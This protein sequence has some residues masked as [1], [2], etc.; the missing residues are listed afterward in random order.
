MPVPLTIT[1]IEC[2]GLAARLPDD[3]ELGWDVD[4][5]VVYA[6]RDCN[7]RMDIVVEEDDLTD[8]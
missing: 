4:D 2:G 7:H 6:C 1:C 8:E 3:P 5:V